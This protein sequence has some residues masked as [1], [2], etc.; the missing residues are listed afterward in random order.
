MILS[1]EMS[2]AVVVIAGIF[3]ALMAIF[4]LRRR[5]KEESE[6]EGRSTNPEDRI[7][8]QDEESQ[9][10]ID[11]IIPDAREQQPDLSKKD[12]GLE[13]AETEQGA[14]NLMNDTGDQSPPA[15][16]D[17]DALQGNNVD[18]PTDFSG[19]PPDSK[20]G[21]NQT[22]S[23]KKE[24]GKYRGLKRSKPKPKPKKNKE[25]L[26]TKEEST[27]QQRQRPLSIE[28]RLLF[29]RDGFCTLSLIA[30]RPP[31]MTEPIVV[32]S[33]FG[34]L[35][36]LGMQDDWF[37]DV[38]PDQ[39]GN[40][41]RNGTDWTLRKG[42]IETNW[43]LR[44]RNLYILAARSDLRGFISQSCV[45]L[46]RTHAVLCT[47]DIR[48]EVKAAILESGSA[49]TDPI[50]SALGLPE[51]WLVY[52]DIIP[53]NAITAR[54]DTDILNALR[55]LPDVEISLEEGIKIGRT[56]WLA[57]YPPEIRIYGTRESANDVQIDGQVAANID[58]VCRAPGWDSEGEHT[59]WCKGRSKSYS[60]V[61]FKSSCEWRA[62]HKFP[63]EQGSKISIALC[64]P[65]IQ[66]VSTEAND[67]SVETQH[68]YIS[69]PATN[70]I[71]L[72]R[73][74][75]Q[76]IIARSVS[77]LAEFDC[78]ALP[79]FK[80]VWALPQD[81]LHCDKGRIR[82]LHLCP[83]S[84]ETEPIEATLDHRFPADSEVDAWCRDILD[85]CRKGMQIDPDG[86]ATRA[87][88]KS[89]RS[90]ARRIWRSRR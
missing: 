35:D 41:L 60:I 42:G 16:T 21:E 23:K 10:P 9:P 72:G 83:Y 36:L 71:I 90:L 45:R 18:K 43:S 20:K 30:R 48:D 13:Q 7:V 78:V 59:V 3:A 69:V 52:K 12:I 63:V 79:D 34:R 53:G 25:R 73:Q 51:G 4:I 29:D 32:S 85:A 5:L 82:V 39:L 80:P 49:V 66:A 17:K 50:D 58:G 38:A 64:G 57:G 2:L 54:E 86:E 27:P 74:P 70:P 61:P 46:G 81:A 65:L 14:G 88:W 24:P 68:F 87:L 26:N 22:S 15:Q 62:A 55:P 33:N 8:N 76:R 37:Q 31:K 75:G 1:E 19:K 89:C 28:V 11:K 44:G 56:T 67:L 77:N 40:I 6:V 84:T 47:E